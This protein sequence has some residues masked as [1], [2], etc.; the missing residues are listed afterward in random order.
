MS[1]YVICFPAWRFVPR[2]CS[3]ANGPFRHQLLERD[4]VTAQRACSRQVTWI[5]PTLADEAEVAS[6]LQERSSCEIWYPWKRRTF[7]RT[8]QPFWRRKPKFSRSFPSSK[9]TNRTNLMQRLAELLAQRQD[10]DSLP[11]PEP[12]VF[13]G[14]PLHFPNWIKSFET[15]IKGKRRTLPKAFITWANTQIM[16]LR[17]LQRSGLLIQCWRL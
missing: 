4:F 16:K 11:R 5:P 1:Q 3:A 10:R 9:R 2:D 12:E 14:N 15:F 8:E 6:L 7:T 17:K 13:C